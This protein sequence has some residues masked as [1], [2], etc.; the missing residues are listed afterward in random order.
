MPRY[1]RAQQ[2][3][4]LSHVINIEIDANYSRDEITYAPP[5]AD[6][7]LEIELG[8]VLGRVGLGA[9]TNAVTGTG[10]GTRTQIALGPLAKVGDYRAL[11]LGDGAWVV[12]D[13]DGYSLGEATSAQK[14]E[15]AQIE[16]QINTGG[17]AWVEGAVVT[18]TV[19]PGLGQVVP[20]DFTA[21]DGSQNVYGVAGAYAVVEGETPL[22]SFAVVRG[23]VAVTRE[24]VWPEG[25][26][27]AQIARALAQM[28]ART[29]L[30]R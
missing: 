27:E 4:V 7:T 6:Q 9:V 1:Y 3:K 10:N 12:S 5:G 18:F 15:N 25:A 29:L 24:L 2:P 22:K 11:Y 17:T 13:P 23:A 19:A 14:F 28:E 30:P 21:T 8:Q 20:I 26:T 16:F